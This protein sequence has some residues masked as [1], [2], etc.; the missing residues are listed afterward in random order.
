[1]AQ[2]FKLISSQSKNV[3]RQE[4]KS[5]IQ[6]DGVKIIPVRQF[7]SEEGDFSELIRLDQKG[8]LQVL[9]D[10]KL[11][12][13]NR[14]YLFPDS[15]KAWHF[16][17]KQDE[18]WYVAPNMSLVAGLWDL[19]AD[20]PT[21]NASQKIVLGGSQSNMLF[22]PR[23]VAHGSVNYSTDSVNLYYFVN[24]QFNMEDPDEQR[25]HWDA[26]GKEFWYP[27]RD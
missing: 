18:I 22:I 12:Q 4:Y 23:G 19:R 10:F 7:L 27:E 6:I 24:Q 3:F 26:L 5:Q 17:Y 15:I 20:S 16:H 1:M 25:L 13:V 14:T 2:P 8:H 21:A 11:Q 9:P